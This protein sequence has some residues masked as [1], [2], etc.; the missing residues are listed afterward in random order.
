L[1]GELHHGCPGE[2]LT[3]LRRRKPRSF[4]PGMNATFL[5]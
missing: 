5:F 3:D 1:L 4:M 2:E